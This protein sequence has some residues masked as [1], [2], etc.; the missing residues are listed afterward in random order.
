MSTR[1]TI[2]EIFV[3][4][5]G[6][7]LAAALLAL[8]GG[9]AWVY[10]AA[11]DGRGVGDTIALLFAIVLTLAFGFLAAQQQIDRR[12][13]PQGSPSTKR[14]PAERRS[15]SSVSP[16]TSPSTAGGVTRQTSPSPTRQSAA[17][18]ELLQHELGEAENIRRR[19]PSLR[20]LGVMMN[21]GTSP[22]ASE[23]D[24]EFWEDRVRSLLRGH[25]RKQARFDTEMPHPLLS[26]IAAFYDPLSARLEHRMKELERIIQEID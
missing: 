24:V 8:A 19:L 14:P 25:P 6:S 18:R 17:L 2:R 11:T 23:T 16:P 10:Q 12:K 26:T 13:R 22:P 20:N 9:V 21:L 7:I 3:S 5:A 15:S 4:A 1:R